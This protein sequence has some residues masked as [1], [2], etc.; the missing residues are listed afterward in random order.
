MARSKA[1]GKAS[2]ASADATPGVPADT[3]HPE[4]LPPPPSYTKA[5]RHLKRCH[6]GL[7][8]LIRRIGP[9][10]LRPDPDSF[11]VLVRSIVA[12]Q[13]STKAAESISARLWALVEPKPLTPQS[14]DQLSEE[15]LQ[16]C[17]LST[18]KR[19]YLRALAE[20]ESAQPGFFEGL[21]GLSDDDVMARL[22]PISGI[23]VW[24]AEM[25]LIFSLGRLDVLPVG[26]LGLRASAQKCFALKDLPGP[27]VL[28]AIAE[29]WRPYRTIAT[30]YLW[31]SKGS[32]PQ[33]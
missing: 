2:D 15:Q 13:I 8:D 18:S 17:G 29:A 14:L 6:P 1:R 21:A 19:R 28:R 31:R 12:Q 22:L 4:A 9:C 11:S 20:Q 23:G 32:V 5:E 33:S 7:A 27:D 10:T 25:F 30:W 16:G 3:T 24:T 26:D